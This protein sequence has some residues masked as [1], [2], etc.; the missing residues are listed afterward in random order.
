MWNPYSQFFK[1]CHHRPNLNES[2]HDAIIFNKI[3]NI[4][5]ISPK[6]ETMSQRSIYSYSDAY[7]AC[8]RDTLNFG[9][10]KQI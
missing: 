9:L 1:T 6:D 4:L 7:F 10:L 2:L 8:R 5:I 3:T